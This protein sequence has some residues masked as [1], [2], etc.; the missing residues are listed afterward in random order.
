MTNKEWLQA[1]WEN[2]LVKVLDIMPALMLVKCK[3]C[4]CEECTVDGDCQKA[5]QNWLEAEHG[6]EGND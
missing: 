5:W 3:F 2:D 4:E 1:E 6:E